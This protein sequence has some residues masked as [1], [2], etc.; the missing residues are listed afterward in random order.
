MPFLARVSDSYEPK[1][2]L[3]AVCRMC[4]IIYPIS[5]G[6]NGLS[7]QNFSSPGQIPATE[8]RAESDL[9][10]TLKIGQLRQSCQRP[11]RRRLS[12]T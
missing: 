6:T 1:N 7:Q 8:Q 3:P 4:Y 5:S 11:A 12:R 10:G 2:P 9:S